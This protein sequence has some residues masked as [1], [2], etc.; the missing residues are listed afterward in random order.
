MMIQ[1]RIRISLILQDMSVYHREA[2]R[3]GLIDLSEIRKAPRTEENSMV[4]K[5]VDT[6]N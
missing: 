6:E 5:S 1:E 2:E 4:K 3:A